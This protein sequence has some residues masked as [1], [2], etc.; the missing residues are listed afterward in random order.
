MKK[1][2]IS[3]TR[4]TW[5]AVIGGLAVLFISSVN[6]KH[7]GLLTGLE[8]EIQ[9]LEQGNN[10]LTESDVRNEIEEIVGEIDKIPVRDVETSLLEEII[11]SNSFIKKADVFVSADNKLRLNI[12]QREPMVRILHSKGKGS[13]SYGGN[14]CI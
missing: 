7:E 1:Y 10:L 14:S 2:K 6:H 12:T 13:N 8:I 5:L 3:Y 11:E 4:I 9:H